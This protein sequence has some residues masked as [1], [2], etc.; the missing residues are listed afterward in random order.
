[1]PVICFPREIKNYKEFCDVV[2]PD[3]VSIDY[4]I[5]PNW[6]IKKSNGIAIQGGMDPKILLEDNKKIEYAVKKYLKTFSGYPYI[7]NLG[8]GVLPETKPETI[9]F[10]VKFIRKKN[11]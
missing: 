5:D 2:K 3:A 7:F 9:D 1:M 6:I 4:N 11:D 8:H 10:I